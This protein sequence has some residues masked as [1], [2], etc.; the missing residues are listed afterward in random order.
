METNDEIRWDALTQLKRAQHM[1]EEGRKELAAAHEKIRLAQELI[2]Q[3]AE[4][5]REN[6]PAV[7]LSPHTTGPG[8][9]FE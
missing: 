8:E 9:P 5:L 2:D 6:P 4:M 3:S 1:I 7:H